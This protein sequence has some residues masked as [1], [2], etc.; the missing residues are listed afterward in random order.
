MDLIFT[1]AGLYSRFRNEGYKIPK[2]LLPWKH[3]TILSEILTQMQGFD[4]IFLIANEKNYGFMNHVLKIQDHFGIP[5]SNLILVSDT[6]GQAETASI[7]LEKI[8]L[9]GPFLIH[10]ID[11]ILYNRDYK[12]IESSLT[13]YSG[14][15]DLFVS[16]NHEYSYVLLDDE[17]CIKEISEKILISKFATSGLYGFSSVDA[18]KSFY[19]GQ[20][21]I[22]EIYK[23]MI[24]GNEK[25]L[26]GRIYTEQ[27]TLV[28]GTP[29][30][31]LNLS[32]CI[33]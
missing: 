18:Y 20:V 19:D 3:H 9:K 25:V 29:T 14:Y 2:Y 22:S 12:L 31:Y 28:L 7:G 27:E 4:N 5:Q 8:S 11:T 21:F 1:M 30:D 6:R 26:G 17:N 23:D 16:N 33:Q 13:K 32:K 15:I 10:N 24:N